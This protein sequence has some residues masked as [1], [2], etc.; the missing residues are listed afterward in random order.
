MIKEIRTDEQILEDNKHIPDEEVKQ[1]IKDTEADIEKLHLEI[2][3]LELMA[4]RMSRVRASAKRTRIGQMKEFIKKLQHI[5]ELRA[6][7]A[8]AMR[9]ES[10]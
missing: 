7:A 2:V 8:D 9:E 4:D 5:L 6:V 1:D 3:P 10:K